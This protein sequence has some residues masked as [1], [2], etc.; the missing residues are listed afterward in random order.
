MMYNNTVEK[1]TNQK[2]YEIHFDIPN[3]NVINCIHFS[4]L[5]LSL[6]RQNVDN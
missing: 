3:A 4:L 1:F 6:V 2:N 5:F